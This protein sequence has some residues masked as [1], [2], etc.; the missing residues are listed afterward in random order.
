MSVESSGGAVK[1]Q[2]EEVISR[3]EDLKADIW[4]I[5]EKHKR[6]HRGVRTL[7]N[8]LLDLLDELADERLFK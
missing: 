4:E 3:A 8:E 1:R 6:D 2:I 5:M 7:M